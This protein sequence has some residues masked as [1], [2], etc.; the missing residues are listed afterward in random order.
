MKRLFAIL[1]GCM[2]ITGTFASCGSGKDSS[3]SE[4][5]TKSSSTATGTEDGTEDGTE[6][7][8]EDGTGAE[9]TTKKTTTKKVTTA[10]ATEEVTTTAKT[11][12]N[13]AATEDPIEPDIKPEDLK[14]G[15]IRGSWRMSEEDAFVEMVF[16]FRADGKVGLYADFSDDFSIIGDKA[17]LDGEEASYEFDGKTLKITDDDGDNLIMERI[18]GSGKSPDGKYK[19]TGGTLAEDYDDADYSVVFC[20]EGPQTFAYIEAAYLYSTNGNQLTMTEYFNGP[21]HGEEEV[22]YYEVKRNT[23]VLAEE[24]GDITT[25]T[26]VD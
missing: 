7:V 1:M 5:S 21:E 3:D 23:L 12:T 22:F 25:L 15:D 14:G 18:E 4:A 8:T 20:I 11:T 9:T 2:L 13:I 6:V 16:E 24:Y 19:V 17:R 26:K 10:P